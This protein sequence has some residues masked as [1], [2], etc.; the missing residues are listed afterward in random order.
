MSAWQPPEPLPGRI[1][2]QPGGRVLWIPDAGDL[3]LRPVPAPRCDI[4]VRPWQ[5]CAAGVRFPLHPGT[6][7]ELH[8]LAREWLAEAFGVPTLTD[9]VVAERQRLMSLTWQACFRLFKPGATIRSAIDAFL[10]G[11]SVRFGEV[12]GRNMDDEGLKLLA[13]FA[14]VQAACAYAEDLR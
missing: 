7:L 5:A 4:E 12:V 1:S 3:E 13:Q 14:A 6:L 2:Y 9:A 8:G 10:D 11:R